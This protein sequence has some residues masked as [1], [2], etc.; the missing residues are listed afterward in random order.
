MVICDG[1]ECHNRH[2]VTLN[3]RLLNITVPWCGTH[4]SDEPEWE[5]LELCCDS[6]LKLLFEN[7]G[8]SDL[9]KLPHVQMVKSQICQFKNVGS[10]II[11][12]D[13]IIKKLS[14]YNN[15][16]IFEVFWQRYIPV[17]NNRVSVTEIRKF[18]EW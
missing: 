1:S 18:K 17:T 7:L 8:K 15:F 11:R 12:H 14:P 10:Y 3:E 9:K 16:G 2:T 4:V 13:I 6:D 5:S